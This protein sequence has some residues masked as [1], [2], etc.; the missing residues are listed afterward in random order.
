MSLQLDGSATVNNSTGTVAVSLTTSN[1]SG[2]IVVSIVS[3]SATITSVT[4]TGLT[5]TSRSTANGSGVY[6]YNYT[7]PYTSNFS[8]SIT[9]VMGAAQYT[10]VTAFGVS[11]AATSN[12]FDPNASL[13]ATSGNAAA[14]PTISTS[15]ANDFLFVNYEPSNGPP[16]TAG[17]GWTLINGSLYQYV[18]YKI[19][20]STQSNLTPPLAASGG[21]VNTAT[22]DAIISAGAGTDVLMGQAI[23]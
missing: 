8:G 22:V 23:F 15:D 11:G 3:N 1:G 10:T 9:V 7:A 18:A 6:L 21:S 13:P 5:F 20:S 12:Y 19:V 2:V 17:S 16:Y 4:A 14:L